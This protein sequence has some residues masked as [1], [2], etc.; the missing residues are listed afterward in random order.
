MEIDDKIK[1]LE[2]QNYF[3]MFP[4]EVLVYEADFEWRHVVFDYSLLRQSSEMM[5]IALLLTGQTMG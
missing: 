2:G 3:S 4:A 5:E 1:E